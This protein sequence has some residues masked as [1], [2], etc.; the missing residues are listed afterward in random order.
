MS[1]GGGGARGHGV[2][3]RP[4][5]YC[6][7]QDLGR[8]RGRRA[9]LA[10][11]GAMDQRAYL[12]ANRLL[13][14][15]PEAAALEVTLGGLAFRFAVDAVIALTGADCAASLDGGET[16]CWR[17]VRARTGQT[18]RL[19]YSA[20]GM[21]AYLAFPGGLDVGRAFGSASAVARDGLP[22]LLGRPLRAGEA[23]R[24]GT[25]EWAG[26]GRRVPATLV[27][28]PGAELALPLVAG[29]EWPQFS[30]ADRDRVFAAEWTV[31]PA[32]DRTAV[33]LAGPA[34]PSGPRVLDSVPLVDG[35][36]QVTGD[37]RPLVFMRDRPT[38]GGYAKLG[39]VDPV[40]LDALAQARPGTAVRFVRA[41]PEA[42]RRAMARRESFFGVGNPRVRRPARGGA[43]GDPA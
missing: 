29:Y 25:P 12:W 43:V 6:T 31:D 16:G 11:G 41:D 17:T 42:L 32:S 4:G 14:N 38:I 5:P 15:D 23:L 19:G 35:T 34:L 8:R 28:A 2:V 13:G 37:G 18:L 21:R 20:T 3:E 1:P 24:W 9:G 7:V 10:P 27:P 36:V 33:R 26:A 30:P 39:S 40:A 22:G